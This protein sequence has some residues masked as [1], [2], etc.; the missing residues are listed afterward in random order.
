MKFQTTIAKNIQIADDKSNYDE[1]CK[2]LLADKL[3]LAWI[4]KSCVKEYHNYGVKEIAENYIEGAPHVS[5]TAVDPDESNAPMIHGL[6]TEDTTMTE[7]TIYYDIRFL[8]ILPGSGEQIHL[9]INVEA[10]NDFYPG[11]PLIT[12][13]IY[14][15]CRMI[16]SQ[17]GSVFTESHYEKVNKVYSIWICM[18]PPKHRENTI[19][20]YVI[21]EENMAGNVKEDSRHY[22]LLTAVMICLGKPDNDKNGDI[23]RLLDIL[24]STDTAPDKKKQILRDDYDIPMTHDLERKVSFMC[25]LSKGVEEK[26]IRKGIQQGSLKKEQEVIQSMCDNGFSLDV[27]AKV[28]KLPLEQVQEVLQNSCVPMQ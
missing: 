1:A 10:Q 26:G 13:A 21:S 7:G 14:Y 3:I 8:A 24:L 15:C 18:N 19:T 22:D 23:L 12:R 5:Q 27:I 6:N 20:R 9:I 4:M 11:Y 16:S 17:Y 2:R 25:N 28:M